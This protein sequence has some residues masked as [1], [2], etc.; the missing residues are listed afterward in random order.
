MLYNDRHEVMTMP[1]YI[2]TKE[3]AE[4]LGISPRQVRRLIDQEL[5]PAIVVA[6][7]YVIDASDLE[8]VPPRQVGY[9]KGKPRKSTSE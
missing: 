1:D 8:K 9:P 7:N 3:A 5:L 6:G 4:K 2:S